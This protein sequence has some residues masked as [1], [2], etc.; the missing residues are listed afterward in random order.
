MQAVVHLELKGC[1]H[2]VAYEVGVLRLTP[3]FTNDGV[4]PAF[5]EIFAG[6]CLHFVIQVL[7][8]SLRHGARRHMQQVIRFITCQRGSA[9]QCCKGH[10]SFLWEKPIFDP[11]QKPNP[12]TYN[13]KN[14]HD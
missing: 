12:L 1:M 9:R 2:E 4:I 8:C 14:L 7:P 11:S 5:H 6:Q 10:V 13:H 3:R